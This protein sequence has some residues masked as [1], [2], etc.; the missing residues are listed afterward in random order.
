MRG[1]VSHSRP[2]PPDTTRPLTE[3]LHAPKRSG[4]ADAAA[5]QREAG[6]AL[7]VRLHPTRRPG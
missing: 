2:A 3:Q 4:A 7:E 6:A 5:S 1:P